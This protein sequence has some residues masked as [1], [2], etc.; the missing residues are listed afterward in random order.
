VPTNWIIAAT[1][2]FDSDG[3]SDLLWRDTSSGLAALWFLNGVQVVSTAAV[4]TV[5][6]DWTIQGVNAD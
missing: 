4:G 1:G 3:R 2:D 5:G 6:T